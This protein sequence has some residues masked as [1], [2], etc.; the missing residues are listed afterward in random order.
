VKTFEQLD[1]KDAP[2]IHKMLSSDEKKLRSI[3]LE[4][5]IFQS[6]SDVDISV[7]TLQAKD[8][9]VDVSSALEGLKHKGLVAIRNDGCISGIYPFS[10]LPTHHQVQ[11]KDGKSVYAMCAIDSLGIAY[12]LNQDVTIASS[13]SHCKSHIVIQ[14][15]GGEVSIVEPKTA[16]ALHVTLGDYKDWASTC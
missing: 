13:C 9:G 4:F 8:A 11:V 5:I 2:N 15:V 10:A 1:G 3:L 16:L 14:I 6:S 12:E 7:V